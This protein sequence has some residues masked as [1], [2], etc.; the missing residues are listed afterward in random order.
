MAGR[1]SAKVLEGVR[2]LE[3]GSGMATMIM[4]DFGADV[5]KIEPPAAAGP[6]G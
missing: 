2:V 1:I 4:A 5:V 6:T 3:L